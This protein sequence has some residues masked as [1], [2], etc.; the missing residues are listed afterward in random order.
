MF[1]ERLLS[2]KACF[3]F[4]SRNHRLQGVCYTMFRLL[5]FA[6][7]VPTF[8]ICNILQQ[9]IWISILPWKIRRANNVGPAFLQDHGWLN[10]SLLCLLKGHALWGQMRSLGL[11][12]VFHL[13][14]TRPTSFILSGYQRVCDSQ[15]IQN[16]IRHCRCP[17]WPKQWKD[18]A[19]F[20]QLHDMTKF[21]VLKNYSHATVEDGLQG[22]NP[23]SWE[24]G[25]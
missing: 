2:A 4:Q 13:F 14:Y 19:D 3:K 7:S 1:I 18:A 8:K 25:T 12:N 24:A 9:K 11:P 21:P 20:K 6:I 23:G 15:G 5:K 16:Q 10:L 17:A 22:N